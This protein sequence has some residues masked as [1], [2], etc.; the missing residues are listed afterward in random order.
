M[1]TIVGEGQGLDTTLVEG[2]PLNQLPVLGVVK[3]D[4]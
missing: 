1:L 4:E 2:V 3:I